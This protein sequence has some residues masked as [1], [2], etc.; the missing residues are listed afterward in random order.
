MSRFLA[1]RLVALALCCC[2]VLPAAGAPRR[3]DAHFVADRVLVDAPLADGGHVR[4]WT[5]TG[6]GATLLYDEAVAR[7]KLPTRPAP[8]EEIGSDL[9]PGTR[10]LAAPLALAPSPFPPPPRLAFVVPDMLRG[11]GL[12]ADADGNVGQDWFAGHVWTWDYPAG[13][14]SLEDAGWRPPAGAKVVPVGFVGSRGDEPAMWFPRIEVALAGEPTDMLLDSGATT[15]LTEE[16]ARRIGGPRLRA[17]SMIAASRIAA[18]RAA[19]PDWRVVE[20]AQGGTGALMIE[21][22]D[23]RIAGIQVGPVWFTQQRDWAFTGFMSSMTDKPVLGA[24]GGNAFHSL[25]MT[26]D[27]PGRRAAFSRRP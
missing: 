6:G 17:T 21:V 19:H 23:V 13:T 16:A 4:F 5:D 27:Y 24:I 2:A 18:W 22:P 15:V 14:L 12:P 11:M 26:V 8:A 7:L 25:V 10:M 1:A 9:G 20:H 3:L